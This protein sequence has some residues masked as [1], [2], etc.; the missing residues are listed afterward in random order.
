[1]EYW[2]YTVSSNECISLP[3]DVSGTFSLCI[4]QSHLIQLSYINV[5]IRSILIAFVLSLSLVLPININDN[6]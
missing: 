5:F 1:M 2:H 3:I 4:I 6:L